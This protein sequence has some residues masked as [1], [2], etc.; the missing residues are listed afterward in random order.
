M[1]REVRDEWVRRLRSGDYDQGTGGLRRLV[2]GATADGPARYCCLGVLCEV[3]RERGLVALEG[4][5][6][7]RSVALP[8]EG[9]YGGVLPPTVARWA[10]LYDHDE[11]TDG[12][13]D[14]VVLGLSLSR[15]NDV[16]S[17]GGGPATFA[18]L[19]DLIEEHL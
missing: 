8:H 5:S 13:V 12:G 11:G 19:A 15:W 4:T 10:G 9:G 7:Y 14:P 3:A 2:D 18:Q 1:N 6:T 16:G 17:T